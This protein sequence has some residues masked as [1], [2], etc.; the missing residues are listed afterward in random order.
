M[1]VYV[2]DNLATTW[3]SSGTTDNFESI[4]LSGMSGDAIEVKGV[5]TDSEWLS[6]VEVS[7]LM[8][9]SWRAGKSL[10]S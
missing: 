7:G 9:Q 2:N 6:I 5:L 4:D 8:F 10:M 1:E 3:I